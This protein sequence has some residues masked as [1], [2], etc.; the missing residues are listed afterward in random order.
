MTKGKHLAVADLNEDVLLTLARWFEAL[1]LLS[2]GMVCGLFASIVSPLTANDALGRHA[3][4]YTKPSKLKFCG[5]ILRRDSRKNQYMYPWLMGRQY[6]LHPSSPSKWPL[7]E[8][9]ACVETSIAPNLASI[10]LRGSN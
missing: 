1:E 6:T 2:W 3:S 7:P 8:L 9:A 10:A 5:S 4:V